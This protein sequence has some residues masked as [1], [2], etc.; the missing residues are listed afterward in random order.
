MML[1]R[2]AP[3]L[4]QAHAWDGGERLVAQT[5]RYFCN[6]Y[7]HPHPTPLSPAGKGEERLKLFIP[8]YIKHAESQPLK[9]PQTRHAFWTAVA[10]MPGTPYAMK[11]QLLKPFF[12]WLWLFSPECF[13]RQAWPRLCCQPWG[14]PWLLQAQRRSSVFCARFWWPVCWRFFCRLRSLCQP[15]LFW[16]WAWWRLC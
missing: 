5:I 12:C 16:R 1:V 9:A 3:I 4:L 8:W 10:H 11:R 7:S 13:W 14:L 2:L 15:L 6:G